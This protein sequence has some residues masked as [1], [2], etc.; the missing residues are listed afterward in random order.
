MRFA[1]SIVPLAAFVIALGAVPVAGASGPANVQPAL[2]APTQRVDGLDAGE[3]MGLTWVR[4]YTLPEAENPMFGNS[5]PCVRLGRHGKI[6][7]GIG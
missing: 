4:G 2:L 5:A 1:R 3:A 7:V 6:L